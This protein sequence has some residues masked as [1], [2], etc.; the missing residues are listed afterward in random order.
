MKKK[1]MFK[2]QRLFF[3]WQSLINIRLISVCFFEQNDIEKEEKT[4]G[5]NEHYVLCCGTK[6]YSKKEYKNYVK[7]KILAKKKKK[8]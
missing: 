6:N 2:V 4:R 3:F 5:K 8:I 7:K 1:S